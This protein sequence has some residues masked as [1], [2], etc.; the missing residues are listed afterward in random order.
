[1]PSVHAGGNDIVRPSGDA[2]EEENVTTSSTRTTDSPDTDINGSVASSATI[3]SLLNA[4]NRN[5][6]GGKLGKSRRGWN[7]VSASIVQ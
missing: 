7:N 5:V 1:M 2:A 4:A 3:Y 6:G